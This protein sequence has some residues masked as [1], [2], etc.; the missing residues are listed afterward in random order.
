M[1]WRIGRGPA[2]HTAGVTTIVDAEGREVGTFRRPQDANSAI[3]AVGLW[4]ALKA[5]PYPTF[6]R[7][8]G[9]VAPAHTPMPQIGPA[10]APPPAKEPQVN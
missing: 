5:L 6:D 4:E 1:S 7:V 8:L 2:D 9:L 10:H 3:A